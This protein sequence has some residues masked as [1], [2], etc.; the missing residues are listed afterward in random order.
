LQ[1]FQDSIRAQPVNPELLALVNQRISEN[2][3]YAKIRFRSSTNS[4]D[5]RGFNGAGLYDSYTGIP[6]DPDK[7][8]EDAIRN[9]WAS[10]WNISAYEEREYF[11]IDQRSVAMAVLV[12]RSF[13]DEL[14]NGVVITENLYNEYNPGFTINVQ[15]GEISITNPE[16][17]YTADQI[18]KY[19]WNDI[20]EYINHSNVPGMA[21]KTVLSND[22]ILL[23]CAY[24]QA[25]HNHYCILNDECLP[26]DI[27]FK[28]ELVD[29]K[30]TLYIKQARL[31]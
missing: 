22:E 19:T 31:Y 23:L 3:G 8:I 5:I 15:V 17:G 2:G 1:N 10:L 18:I 20:I 28:L 11:K 29:G 6:G 13:P 16:G 30:R 25:I 26:M 24:C 12:H 4:E 14:A 7:S 21:G 27:E 9:V